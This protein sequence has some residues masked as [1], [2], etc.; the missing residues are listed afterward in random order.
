MEFVEEQLR[1]PVQAI[2]DLSELHSKVQLVW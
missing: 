2:K 1:D